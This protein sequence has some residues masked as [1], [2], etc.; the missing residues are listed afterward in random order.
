VCPRIQY[1]PLLDKRDQKKQIEMKGGPF[2]FR[3]CENNLTFFECVS[4][5][6]YMNQNMYGGMDARRVHDATL[7]YFAN[8]VFENVER[9]DNNFALL[10]KDIQKNNT[11]HLT[12]KRSCV[13]NGAVK[14][15][16]KRFHSVEKGVAKSP[17]V[18][19]VEYPKLMKGA[20]LRFIYYHKD[21]LAKPH[22]LFC[23]YVFAHLIVD[24][25][26]CRMCIVGSSVEACRWFYPLDYGDYYIDSDLCTL[27]IRQDADGSPAF[28]LLEAEEE[29]IKENFDAGFSLLLRPV[30]FEP[31]NL[32]DGS[33]VEVDFLFEEERV[34]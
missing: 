3:T 13:F 23:K 12:L 4:R 16:I 34:E 24:Q 18:W 10:I 14:Q 15:W 6:M 9:Y 7:M 22:R 8:I 19:F 2:S 32:D 30:R 11:K 29:E 25:L 27:I 5:F 26:N 21:Y 17:E 1:P 20:F 33:G 31:D 28:S